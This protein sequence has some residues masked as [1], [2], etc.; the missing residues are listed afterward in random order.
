MLLKCDKMM[1]GGKHSKDTLEKK[2]DDKLTAAKCH[3]SE[4]NNNTEPNVIIR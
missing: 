4:V 2:S 1:P 3:F